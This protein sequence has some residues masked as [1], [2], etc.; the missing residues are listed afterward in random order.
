MLGSWE[1]TRRAVCCEKESERERD[2]YSRV[3]FILQAP[4]QVAGSISLR[5]ASQIRAWYFN[6]VSNKQ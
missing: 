1:L 3:P 2:P 5:F 6:M 4:V